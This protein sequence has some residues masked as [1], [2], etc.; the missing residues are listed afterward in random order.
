MCAIHPPLL[1]AG[2]VSLEP[3][4]QISTGH[5][6]TGEEVLCHPAILEVIRR[7]FVRE[8]VHEEFTTRLQSVCNFLH[9]QLVVLHVLEEFNA[10]HSVIH[11]FLKS[12]RDHIACD[13]S[14]VLEPLL[15]RSCV[16]V[17]LLTTRVGKCSN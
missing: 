3:K 15:L 11:F 17:K 1:N 14:D 9:E 16:N 13:D 2:Q 4:Q 12:V 6:T 5:S 10:D 8:D 7:A